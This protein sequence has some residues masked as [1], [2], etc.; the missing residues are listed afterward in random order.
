[1]PSKEFWI[2]N[3]L[4]WISV[5]LVNVF[6][7]T[8]FF[9]ENNTAYGYSFVICGIAFLMCIVL[10]WLILKFRIAE[11]KFL[12]SV[13]LSAFLM[14][15]SSFLLVLIYLP[16]LDLLYNENS[17]RIKIILGE[18]VDLAPVFFIWTLIYVSYIIFQ[19]QQKLIA[20]KYKLSLELKESEL[21][22]LRNQLSPHFLFNSINNIRSLVLVD[23]EKARSGLMEMSDLLRYVLNYQKLNTVPLSEEMEVVQ[24]YLE[25]NKIHLGDNAEFVVNVDKSLF[26]FAIP[27]MSVQL[28]VENAIKHGELKNNA[29]VTI[30]AIKKEKGVL[31]QVSNPGRL[32]EKSDQGIGLRNLHYRLENVFK[33]RV[34]FTIKEKDQLVTAEIYISHD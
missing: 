26:S 14:V 24:S 2:A 21:S 18:W 31:I 5:Y 13:L 29:K 11:K 33:N 12:V 15:V 16:I 32:I 23:P 3:S 34:H 17:L 22:N 19:Q 10:R 20:D 4:G 7:Q 28:L 6:F 9:T 1:M 8:N 27:P 30:S 25:L